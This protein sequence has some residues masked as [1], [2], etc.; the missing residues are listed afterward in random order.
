MLLII[1]FSYFRIYGRTGILPL[2]INSASAEPVL[3]AMSGK[4]AVLYE[5]WGQSYCF[6][7]G[8][9]WRE[10]EHAR[11]GWLS[12]R[13]LISDMFYIVWSFPEMGCRNDIE[14]RG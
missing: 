2:C 3:Y 6:F 1:T 13:F 12:L 10:E 7:P 5:Q 11:G 9:T 14:S 8:L 4:R